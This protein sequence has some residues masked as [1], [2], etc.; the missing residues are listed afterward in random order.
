MKIGSKDF[1]VLQGGDVKFRKW[2][3]NGEPVYKSKDDLPTFFG[4]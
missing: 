3:T 1:R 2:P 4:A